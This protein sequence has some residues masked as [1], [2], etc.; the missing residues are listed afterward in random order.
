MVDAAAS[1]GY[2]VEIP[3]VKVPIVRATFLSKFTYQTPGNQFLAATEIASLVSNFVRVT[4]DLLGS[5]KVPV[6]DRFMAQAKGVVEGM[7]HEPN[8]RLLN[9]LRRLV[10]LPHSPDA[11]ALIDDALIARYYPSDP[12][13][14]IT[15]YDNLITY[16]KSIPYKNVFGYGLF[17]KFIVS[18]FIDTTMSFRYGMEPV[19]WP[20]SVFLPTLLSQQGVTPPM[21]AAVGHT[22]GTVS[23]LHQQ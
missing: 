1:I 10:G 2:L 8:S 9:Q 6:V 22:N 5:N 14:G 3:R 7:V 4:G 11:W 17:G 23:P 20:D 18:E 16:L 19:A 15:H 21:G 13:L 12:T